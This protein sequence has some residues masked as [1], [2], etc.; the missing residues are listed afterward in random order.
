MYYFFRPKCPSV[1][2]ISRVEYW[3][4]ETEPLKLLSLKNDFISVL[5][6]ISQLIRKKTLPIF[7]GIWVENTDA[8]DLALR[9]G[10]RGQIHCLPFHYSMGDAHRNTITDPLKFV[11]IGGLTDYRRD[12]DGLLDA[13]E[14]LFDKGRHN[15][16]LSLLGAPRD[17]REK[18]FQ[19]I[20]RCKRLKERGL[21]IVFY[22]EHIPEEIM[23]EKISSANIIINPIK[24]G[25]YGTGTSGAVIKAIQYAK[26]GI[27]PLDSL[28]HKELASSSLFYRNIDELPKIIENLLNDPELLNILSEN[29]ITNSVA[30]S[31][32]RMANSF[33]ESLLKSYTTC[34][35]GDM[36]K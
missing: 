32:D 12:Y 28:H 24:V 2:I 5:H 25:T 9:S 27:Y 18:A 16:T 21:P 35:E 8:Y 10:Y 33:Q 30:F 11:V 29:A 36:I 34:G 26:P 17:H 20:Y 23:E 31:L 6:N 14:K 7:N 3:F 13:F 4:G 1:K 22:T 15:V 19:I